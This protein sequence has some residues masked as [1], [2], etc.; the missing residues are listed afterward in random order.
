MVRLVAVA[1]FVTLL[2]A[3]D[4]MPVAPASHGAVSNILP[5]AARYIVAL[6]TPGTIPSALAAAIKS[7]GGR[8]VRTHEGTGLVLVAGLSAKSATAL[9]TRPEVRGIV[10]DIV[11][12]VIR[13]DRP[14]QLFDRSRAIGA[15]HVVSASTRSY[16]SGDPHN[17]AF[18]AAGDQWNMSVIHADSAWE[19]TT[20]GS[21]TAV[22]ILDSGIDT[23]HIEFKG[24]RIDLSKCTSF[25]YAAT[26]TLMLNPLPFD[27]DVVGHGT[28]VSGFISTNGVNLA[29]VAP[30]AKIVMVRVIDD[31]GSAGL[32]SIFDGILYA[33][34]AGAPVIN[35]SFGGYIPRDQSIGLTI[36]D[37]YERVIS[38]AYSHGTI[39]VAAA[40]NEGLNTNTGSAPTGSYA[41]STNSPAGMLHVLS[42]GAIAPVNQQNF[43]HI[44]S[45]SNYGA[46]GVAVFAPGGDSV[47]GSS[48]LDFV[49]GPCSSALFSQCST[50]NQ[51][52]IGAGTSFA[53]PHAAAEAAVALSQSGF[54]LASGSIEN[55]EAATAVSP[56]GVRRDPNYGY[57]VIDV[58]KA[59]TGCSNSWSFGP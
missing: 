45:Y 8:V 59:G 49:I 13:F 42:V 56:T 14:L 11:Q 6:E 48:Q 31:S 41:D 20:R 25:A 33:A 51:Y 1:A 47:A 38:Y 53:S 17:A 55:C 24:G 21:N 19:V 26:D 46:A 29:S 52:V 5:A 50:Q 9:G 18:Y 40:G 23:A 32:F 34:D 16:P 10:P 39:L 22:Y 35:M 44:A 3:C 2:A 43:D 36:A 4:S 28:V 54:S 15:A 12:R 7:A 58:L 27:N 37:L 30:A 57:G